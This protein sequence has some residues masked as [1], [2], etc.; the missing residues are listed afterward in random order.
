M[1]VAIVQRGQ[2]AT[3]DLLARTFVD[4]P[5]VRVLWDRRAR[6]R[7]HSASPIAADRRG[8]DRRRR[9]PGRWGDHHYVLVNAAALSKALQTESI[10]PPTADLTAMVGDSQDVQ[11]DVELA[12]RSDVNLL[13]TGGDPLARKSL[14]HW[15]HDWSDRG[16]GPFVA[17][18]RLGSVE[19]LSGSQLGCPGQGRIPKAD[20]L[21]AWV[22]S[23][24]GGTLLLE[25]L[26]DLSWALQTELLHFLERRVTQ[27]RGG[28]ADA[29]RGARIMA[30][31]SYELLDRIASTRFRPDLFYRLN[32][33]RVAVPSATA[34]MRLT[35]G[36]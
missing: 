34:Q 14:A 24:R 6:D 4:D 3:F 26:F 17:L 31:T 18:D 35:I 29:S 16:G 20:Q 32:V 21:E 15:V 12:I 11:Q 13:I 1:Q 28:Q 36:T 10:T 23:A 5:N 7:R 8:R 2:F 30:A 27:P 33:I 22:D 25:E 9:S 19:C